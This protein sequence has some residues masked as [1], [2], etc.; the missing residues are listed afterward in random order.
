MSRIKTGDIV[1]AF[2]RIWPNITGD[3]VRKAEQNQQIRAIRSPFSERSGLFYDPDSI[4][5]FIKGKVDALEIS[6]EEA[7][8]ILS[9]LGINQAQL[10]L[11]HSI[12][13]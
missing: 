9:D 1:R 7:K 10:R 4:E 13:L 2:K 8:I 11:I 6:Q 5:E 12:A 3:M